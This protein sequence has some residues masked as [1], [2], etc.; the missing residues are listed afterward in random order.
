MLRPALIAFALCLTLANGAAFAQTAKPDDREIVVTGSRAVDIKDATQFARHASAPVDGQLAKFNHAVCPRVLG[1][2]DPLA[3]QI[4]DRMSDVAVA[5]GAQ[6]AKRP[7]KGNMVLIV[8]DDGSDLVR[9][10]QKVRSHLI[11][12]L[13]ADELRALIKTPGPVRSWTFTAVEN[14]DGQGISDPMDGSPVTLEVRSASHISLPTQ[15]SIGVAIVVINSDALPGKSGVQI[16]DYAAMRTLARTNPVEGGGKIETILALFGEGGAT[17]PELSAA[18]LAYLQSLYAMPGTRDSRDQVSR[19]ARD[20][21]KA[22]TGA[23]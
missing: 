12:G 1:L 6:V 4:E 5:A 3:T 22:S 20:V 21:R 18:D 13:E 11:V 8:T 17:L 23:P 7:C 19:I 14:E 2:P 9:R 10:M 15:Q 16:A